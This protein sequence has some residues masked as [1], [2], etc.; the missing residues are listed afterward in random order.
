[1][2]AESSTASMAEPG[3]VV[4]LRATRRQL[5]VLLAPALIVIVEQIL[6]AVILRAPAAPSPVWLAVLAVALTVL[7]HV[8]QL[9]FGA[10]L[11][12]RGIQV[13]NVRRRAIAWAELA[14][15]RVQPFMFSQTVVLFERSGRRTRLRMPITGPLMRDRDFD[16]KVELIR[17]FWRR[18]APTV[19]G[20][21]G[22]SAD[23]SL[24]GS[25]GLSGFRGRPDRLRARRSWP[26]RLAAW[27]A[28]VLLTAYG[29]V[30]LAAPGSQR[31]FAAGVV[32]VAVAMAWQAACAGITLTPSAMIVHGI[33][34]RE[35][36][37]SQ[38]QSIEFRRRRGGARLIL[39]LSGGSSVR[40]PA[41]RAGFLL[42]DSEFGDR[43]LT[44]Y[45]WWRYYGRPGE[46]TPGD[47]GLAGVPGI[48]TYGKPAVW[49]RVLLGLLIAAASVVA[50]IT[51]MVLA[52]FAVIGMS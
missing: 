43:A 37:W 4:R 19:A 49:Q 32:A 16:A 9:W 27:Y 8:I 30:A 15:V 25:P 3:E 44:L 45:S 18:Y 6:F 35:I 33:R 2:V 17:Q 34:R 22:P 14:D 36:A 39:I 28:A 47:G 40:L 42:W 48:A 24:A 7:G 46:L 41:P 1:M 13:R 21:A 52:V 50:M 12:S 38:V 20:L 26:Q 51:V 29:L 31:I 11:T 5:A 10:S 23:G